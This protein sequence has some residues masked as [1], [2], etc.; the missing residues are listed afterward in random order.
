MTAELTKPYEEKM[1][2]TIAV[3]ESDYP[4]RTRESPCIGQ[5]YGGLLRHAYACK[6]GRQ[7]YCS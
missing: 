6:P 2:K 5:D 1:K 4:R 7:R 3:L